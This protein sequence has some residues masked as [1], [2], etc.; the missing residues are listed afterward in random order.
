MIVADA[1]AVLRGA[2][3][4]ARGAAAEARLLRRGRDIHA[5]ALIDLRGGAGAAAVR[6]SRG[7]DFGARRAAIDIMAVFPVERYVHDPLLPRIWDLRLE[8]D[9]L[10]CRVR[11]APEGLEAPLLTCDA[12]LANAPGIRADVELVDAS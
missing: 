2:A 12:R 8:S 5:P 10:R 1:S 11:R 3:S 6:R 9:G 4:H 7:Y